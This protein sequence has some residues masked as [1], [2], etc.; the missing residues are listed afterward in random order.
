M[1]EGQGASELP[2]PAGILLHRTRIK[3]PR[4]SRKGEAA[5]AA[6]ITAAAPLADPTH[7]A[8]LSPFAPL[9]GQ[10]PQDEHPAAILADGEALSVPE[11]KSDV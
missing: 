9:A 5:G 4:G 2:V 1:P 10:L 8:A 11:E 6:S 3:G 7:E